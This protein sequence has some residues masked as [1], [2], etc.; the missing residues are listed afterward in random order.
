MRELTERDSV[1]VLRMQ[2][3]RRHAQQ[4]AHLGSQ[5]HYGPA[6]QRG[7][8]LAREVLGRDGSLRA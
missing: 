7:Q 6:A 3:Q 5:Q 8:V 1:H 4:T 2:E